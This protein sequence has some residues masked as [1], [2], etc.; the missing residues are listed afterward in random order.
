MA[1]MYPVE[2]GII[3][4]AVPID[5]NLNGDWT[6]IINVQKLGDQEWFLKAR[7]PKWTT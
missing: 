1:P 4:N 3:S 2:A 6:K 7:K 5:Y